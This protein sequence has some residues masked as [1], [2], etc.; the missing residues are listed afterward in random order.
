M[1]GKLGHI[2]SGIAFR[3]P[4]DQNDSLVD[5][6]PPRDKF[7]VGGAVARQRGQLSARDGAEDPPGN[8][9]GPRSRKPDHREGGHGG[10]RAARHNRLFHPLLL[11]TSAG[12]FG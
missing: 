5:P 8:L 1:A 3:R 12:F 11:S 9:N 7:S 6:L 10:R 4:Q 2:L